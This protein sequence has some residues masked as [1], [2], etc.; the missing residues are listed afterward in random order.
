MQSAQIVVEN[1]LGLRRI[2]DWGFGDA[3][4]S[5]S[6][7]T[8]PSTERGRPSRNPVK[9]IIGILIGLAL[10]AI[11]VVI[12]NFLVG[13]I[14]VWILVK[15]VGLEFSSFYSI[16]PVVFV[17]L[18]FFNRL[19]WIATF[20]LAGVRGST[21]RNIFIG[22]LLLLPAVYFLTKFGMTIAARH[23][24]LDAGL[25][26]DVNMLRGYAEAATNPQ[27]VVALLPA[28]VGQMIGRINPGRPNKTAKSA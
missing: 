22:V 16:F 6:S 9:R 28:A 14:A 17:Y 20:A 24:N 18:T 12:Q 19:D 10:A 13:Y 23:A 1:V 7:Q 26:D 5:S 27:F 15:G 8:E 25:P 2:V 11:L 4:L 21:L 3:R